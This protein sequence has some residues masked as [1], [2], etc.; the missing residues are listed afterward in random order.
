MQC[1]EQRAVATAHPRV[2]PPPK[3]VHGQWTLACGSMARSSHLCWRPSKLPS[4]TWHGLRL[5]HSDVAGQ[6]LP[7]SQFLHSCSPV[8]PPGLSHQPLAKP[9]SREPDLSQRLLSALALLPAHSWNSLQL[10]GILR[11]PHR[12]LFCLV[13]PDSSSLVHPRHHVPSKTVSGPRERRASAL[14]AFVH[15]S[16]PAPARPRSWGSEGTGTQGALGRT[17]LPLMASRMG[18]GKTAAL[19]LTQALRV[20]AVCSPVVTCTREPLHKPM[21]LSRGQTGLKLCPS[22]LLT[23][24]CSPTQAGPGLPRAGAWV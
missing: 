5:P 15:R 21:L 13:S 9:W 16:T 14:H 17:Q 2:T 10:W 1:G 24:P 23:I 12:L 8:R 22:L 3:Q 7:L 19:P 4:S 20:N 11:W 18:H 6:R